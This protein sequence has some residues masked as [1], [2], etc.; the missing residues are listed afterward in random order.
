[1]PLLS[2][3][4]GWPAIIAAIKGA[5]LTRAHNLT[6][7]YSAANARRPNTHVCEMLVA[8]FMARKAILF[9]V[10]TGCIYIRRVVEIELVLKLQK[11][12]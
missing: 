11:D 9:T 5:R 4:L 6:R 3:R 7:A 2:M 12:A 8:V 10:V 1:M